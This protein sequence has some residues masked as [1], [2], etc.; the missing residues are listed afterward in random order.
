LPA[1]LVAAAALWLEDGFHNGPWPYLLVP[2]VVGFLFGMA[3]R[4]SVDA[5]RRARR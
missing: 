4:R 2:I 5:I 3:L 1:L